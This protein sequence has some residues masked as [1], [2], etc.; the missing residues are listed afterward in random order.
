M[1]VLIGIPVYNEEKN[2]V[3]LLNFLLDR[4]P[5]D[6]LVY[7]DGST[8]N[9]RYLLE[10]FIKQETRVKAIQE[11]TNRGYA[12]GFNSLVDSCDKEILVL[13]DC[14][15][16][17]EEDAIPNLLRPFSDPRVG[18]VSGTHLVLKGS[19]KIINR[20]N[21]R[22]YDAKYRL[23]KS[24]SD[25]GEYHH[26]NGLLMGMRVKTVKK[27]GYLGQNQDAF[28]G[29]L[30]VSHGYRVIFAPKARSWFMPPNTLKDYLA[31]RNRVIMGHIN[32]RY[33]FGVSS[34]FWESGSFWDYL[35]NILVSGSNDLAGI[36]G[37]LFA[38]LVDVYFRLKWFYLIRAS[39]GKYNDITW[40]Q[41][42]S[43]KW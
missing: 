36:F 38:S 13:M 12:Y 31:S 26:L 34:F 30:I 32:L 17:P 33:D 23:D 14:D 21:E 9:T 42:R 29:W 20:I 1:S 11:E 7:N 16:F 4:T 28:M 37:L 18:A 5:Y 19:S 15:T 8:D 41:L 27:N 39:P 35:N 43:T 10:A 22:I 2:L 24:L 40:K 6:I 25:R 3:R